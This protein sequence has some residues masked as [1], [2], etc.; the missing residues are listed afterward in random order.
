MRLDGDARALL[1]AG[2]GRGGG[3]FRLDAPPFLGARL[4]GGRGGDGLEACALLFARALDGGGHCRFG[5]EQGALLLAGALGRCRRLGAEAADVFLAFALERFRLRLGLLAAQ[6]L[7]Q[8]PLCRLL[9]FDTQ[10]LGLEPMRIRLEA[11]SLLPLF[12]LAPQVLCPLFGLEPQRV[13]LL[14]L[15]RRLFLERHHLQAL[16]F[17]LRGE[18]ALPLRL[19]GAVVLAETRVS[20][21]LRRVVGLPL[22]RRRPRRIATPLRRARQCRPDEPD[23][24]GS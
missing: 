12:G 1:F 18:L 24:C 14:A 19:D 20:D 8:Q 2:A 11:Q 15:P 13:D 5:L 4:F 23:T 21:A 16:G 3:G 7:V 17:G 9:R 6:R 10:P 22:E